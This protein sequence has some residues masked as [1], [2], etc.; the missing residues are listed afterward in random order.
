MSDQLQLSFHLYDLRSLPQDVLD[1]IRDLNMDLM[2]SQR[3]IGLYVRGG[4]PQSS[5]REII[6][7]L[8]EYAQQHQQQQMGLHNINAAALQQSQQPVLG[9]QLPAVHPQTAKEAQQP[10]VHPM[11][12]YTL[13]RGWCTSKCHNR[14]KPKPWDYSKYNSS[15]SS[16]L[17]P[18]VLYVHLEAFFLAYRTGIICS[19]VNT[20]GT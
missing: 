20:T 17:K 13:M 9:Y 6:G 15:S 4:M 5:G 2:R 14:L 11:S 1:G 18:D 16:K 12:S 19:K 7:M 8:D 3:Q 10:S